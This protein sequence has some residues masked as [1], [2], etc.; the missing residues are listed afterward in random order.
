MKILTF[1]ICTCLSAFSLADETKNPGPRLENVPI[2]AESGSPYDFRGKADYAYPPYEALFKTRT[3]GELRA[4]LE[5]F[6]A[7]WHADGRTFADA[8][9]LESYLR[10]KQALVRI[11]YLAGETAPGDSLMGELTLA[12]ETPAADLEAG[13]RQAQALEEITR[14][15]DQINTRHEELCG[16]KAY[17]GGKPRNLHQLL[18][19]LFKILDELSG[20]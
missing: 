17:P 2:P 9:S 6:M 18:K 20:E 11:Y 7:S 3:Y 10:C 15:A 12:K 19:P 8:S 5:K 13:L 16:E 1:V 4:G 14:L